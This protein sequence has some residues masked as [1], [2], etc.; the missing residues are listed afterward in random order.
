MKIISSMLLG[1][2]VACG[3]GKK[4]EPAGDDTRPAAAPAG[5]DAAAVAASDAAPAA[6]EIPTATDFEAE[7][8]EAIT[9]D[10]LEKE[11]EALEKEIGE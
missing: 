8:N 3:N 11:L 6:D 9:E 2:L 4:D 10:N 5:D 7:V 1:L